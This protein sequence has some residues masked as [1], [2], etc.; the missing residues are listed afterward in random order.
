MKEQKKEIVR[1]REETE[2]K[3]CEEERSQEES[4]AKKS[5][6]CCHESLSSNFLIFNFL[7]FLAM[8]ILLEVF[9]ILLTPFV[10]SVGWFIQ[11]VGVV[12]S[13]AMAVNNGLT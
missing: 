4:C 10:P 6:S 2:E 11:I 5:S 1:R 13:V 9:Q 12:G 7:I 3:L 8:R